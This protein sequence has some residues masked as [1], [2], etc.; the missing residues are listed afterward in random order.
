MPQVKHNFHIEGNTYNMV[1]DLGQEQKDC[2]EFILNLL[3]QCRDNQHLNIDLIQDML[4]EQ[5]EEVLAEGEVI[6]REVIKESSEDFQS[7]YVDLSYE[8]PDYQHPPV[9]AYVEDFEKLLSQVDE[10]S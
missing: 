6:S 9:K 3:D 7:R 1:I 10:E 2:G 4:M 5:Y 8:A